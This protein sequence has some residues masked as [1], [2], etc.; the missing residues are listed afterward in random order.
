M[1]NTK[2]S[3]ADPNGNENS[4]S[5]ASVKGSSSSNLSGL[6]GSSSALNKPKIN[7]PNE[8][9]SQ[10][11]KGAGSARSSMSSEGRGKPVLP[12]VQRQIIKYCI[13]NSKDDLGERIY[14]RVMDKRDDF[15]GFVESLP[16]AQRIELS[17]GLRDFLLKV[18][19]NL[20]DNEEVQ[21]ISEEFGEKHVLFRSNGFRPDFFAVTADAM[22]TECVFLDSAVHQSTETLTAWST[23]TSTMFSSV[24]D[25]FYAEMRRIRR[26][27]NCINNA[28]NKG[29]VD[30]SSDTS[31]DDDQSSRRSNSP[32][33][34][35]TNARVNSNSNG[36]N[37]STT[38]PLQGSESAGNFLCP[39]QVY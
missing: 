32:A 17:Y 19:E 28:K 9:S 18:V 5:D 15:R 27:S 14:R 33:D 13:D 23:L 3:N 8:K 4:K 1:G 12:P 21:R 22:T 31:K 26:A 24:R 7:A 36:N 29:S 30:L 20:T 34:D 11:K 37:S 39:P 6:N 2:S 25:G 10:R 35:E 38:N 16:K